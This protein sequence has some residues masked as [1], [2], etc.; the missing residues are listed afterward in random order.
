VKNYHALMASIFNWIAA[1]AARIMRN[2]KSK[3]TRRAAAK[4]LAYVGG[5]SNYHESFYQS[6]I[7]KS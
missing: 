4:V 7:D 2:G 5:W 1:H 6:P 3:A